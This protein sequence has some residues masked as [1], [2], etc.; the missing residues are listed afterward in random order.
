MELSDVIPWGRTAD[1]YERMFLLSRTDDLPTHRFLGVADGPASFNAEWTAAGGRVTSVDPLYALPGAGI[2]ARYAAVRGQVA[3]ALTANP[4]AYAWGPAPAR[5]PNVPAL[6][7]R[8]DTAMAAFAADFDAGRAAGRYVTGGLPALPLPAD[9]ADVALVSHY[10]FLYSRQVDGP[11]HV[12]AVEEL[13]RVAPEVRIFPL[14]T[15]AGEVSPHVDTVVGHARRRGW[16]VSV[17]QVDY[18]VQR[19]GNQMMVISRRGGG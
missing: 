12:A 18:E 3:A 8:R 7:R 14:L 5:F 11:A 15:L 10:L 6:L 16:G 2:V 19:D 4:G 1:E 13:L 9:A 17:K